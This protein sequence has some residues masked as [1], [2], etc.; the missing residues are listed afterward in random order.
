MKLAI[1]KLLLRCIS[2]CFYFIYIFCH[3][4]HLMKIIVQYYYNSI[5][6]S[7]YRYK[8]CSNICIYDELICT[9]YN[10]FSN[11][12]YQQW[13]IHWGEGDMFRGWNHLFWWSVLLYR[14]IWLETPPFF[15]L[16]WNTHPPP[17]LS[18]VWMRRIRTLTLEQNKSIMQF[19]GL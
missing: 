13:R 5:K 1:H 18:T 3:I 14:D 6:K 12:R 10:F 2:M 16:V 8:L 9:F 17:P 15:I 4:Y 19:K 11:E 7:K